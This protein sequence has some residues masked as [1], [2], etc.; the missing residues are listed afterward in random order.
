MHVWNRR[1]LQVR[2]VDV[3]TVC[4]HVFGLPVG[5]SKHAHSLDEIRPPRPQKKDSLSPKAF[6]ADPLP[7]RT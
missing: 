2:F 4:M 6:L 3:K 7:L 5:L 1:G